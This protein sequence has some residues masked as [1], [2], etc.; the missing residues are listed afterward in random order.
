[1]VAE[2]KDRM[3]QVSGVE[4]V[5]GSGG[6]GKL[7]RACTKQNKKK[8]KGTW[9]PLVIGSFI[10]STVAIMSSSALKMYRFRNCA[11]HLSLGQGQ[12]PQH[13]LENQEQVLVLLFLVRKKKKHSKMDQPERKPLKNLVFKRE[14]C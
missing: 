8:E 9:I 4:N 10:T 11:R 14:L 6:S 12:I 13:K 2:G 7:E 3:K 1:V 5:W